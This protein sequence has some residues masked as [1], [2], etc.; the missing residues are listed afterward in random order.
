MKAT[1]GGKVRLLVCSNSAPLVNDDGNISTT[2][3]SPGGLV[4]MLTDLLTSMGGTWHFADPTSRL[5]PIERSQSGVSLYPVAIDG[6]LA[7]AHYDDISR[8]VLLWLFHYLFDTATTPSFD[9]DL[10]IAWVAYTEVNRRFALSMTAAASGGNDTVAFVNDYHLA[11]VPHF[12]SKMSNGAIGAVIYFHHVPWCGADYFGILPEYIRT[13]ILESLLQCDVVGFHSPR[14]ADAF[15][16]CCTRYLRGVTTAGNRVVYRGRVSRICVAPGPVDVD[17]LNS[18]KDHDRTNE[19]REMLSSRQAGRLAIVRVDRIDLWKNLVRGFAAFELLLA[20]EPTLAS[21]VWFCAVVSLPRISLPRHRA[22]QQM[23]EAAV[24][25]INLRYGRGDKRSDPVSLIYPASGANT[26]HRAVAALS[27]AHV[28]LVNPTYDGLNLVA[29]ESVVLGAGGPLLLSVNAGAYPQLEGLAV[30]VEP[31]DVCDTADA[32]EF[33]VSNTSAGDESRLAPVR[34]RLML[35]NAAVW[36]SSMLAE[37]ERWSIG[38]R[39]EV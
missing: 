35:E 15:V 17:A 18:L 16:D 34:S 32:L 28:T 1:E 24:A 2:P 5:T 8:Q 4:P 7:R 36:F 14:W 27:G 23:C 25:R 33:A 10:T 13:Q 20:R 37:C 3:G 26:R 29:K 12:L 38:G 22:Y 39:R 9:R 6:H 31:F 30:P 19:F 21:D 11:L